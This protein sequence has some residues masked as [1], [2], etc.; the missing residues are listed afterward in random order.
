MIPLLVIL[1]YAAIGLT[2]AFFLTRDTIS[3]ES[4]TEYSWRT[5]D[6][7][8]YLMCA[9]GGLFGG[10]IWPISLPALGF[11]RFMRRDFERN[12]PKMRKLRLDERERRIRDLER[13]LGI[14]SSTP[15]TETESQDAIREMFRFKN[16][17][18]K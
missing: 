6:N 13:E 7:D 17:G 11:A 12:D 16:G 14:G 1:G 18:I 15:T 4:G 10:A 9:V 3:R 2:T 8:D 5:L